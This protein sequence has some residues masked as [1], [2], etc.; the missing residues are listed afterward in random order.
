MI[1]IIIFGLAFF[2]YA[3]ISNLKDLRKFGYFHVIT[4]SFISSLFGIMLGALVSFFIPSQMKE[5]VEVYNLESI[6][7][8]SSIS[9]SFFLGSGSING[10]MKYCCYIEEN[11]VYKMFT[12][13]VYNSSIKY[14]DD[15]PV[16]EKISYVKTDAFINYFSNSLKRFENKYVYKVPKGSIMNNYNLDA[17]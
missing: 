15:K 8:N 4:K 5:V 13:D 3:F 7:D 12:S 1:T 9:G 17:E 16:V 2:V 11:G 14:T 10:S 6:K